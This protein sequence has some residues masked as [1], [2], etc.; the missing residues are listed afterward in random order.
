VDASFDVL[1]LLGG[2][3]RMYVQ[4]WVCTQWQVW[5][6][7]CVPTLVNNSEV[8]NRFLAVLFGTMHSCTRRL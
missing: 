7:F 5:H 3:F 8:C 2:D 4:W 6:P 1:L